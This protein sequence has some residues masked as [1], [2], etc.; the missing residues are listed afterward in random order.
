MLNQ[1]LHNR[2]TLTARLGSGAMGTVYRATDTQ[3]GEAVAVKVIARDLAFDPL[4]RHA[5]V[6]DPVLPRDPRHD[7]H[8]AWDDM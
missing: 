2:Y 4:E 8:H 3:T 1:T 6:G 7:V 5:Y